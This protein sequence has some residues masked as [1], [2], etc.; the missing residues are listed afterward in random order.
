[1]V[2]NLVSQV[3]IIWNPGYNLR[4]GR[5][6]VPNNL[7]KPVLQNRTFVAPDLEKIRFQGDLEVTK[8]GDLGVNVGYVDHS[9]KFQR[10][11]GI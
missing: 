6:G 7:D 3:A 9:C 10:C 4:V 11:G 5:V 2:N 1:M 8:G